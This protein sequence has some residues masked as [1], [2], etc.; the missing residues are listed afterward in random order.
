MTRMLF[1]ILGRRT[2][3]TFGLV[4]FLVGALLATVNLTSRYALKEYVAYQ[5]DRTIIFMILTIFVFVIIFLSIFLRIYLSIYINLSIYRL[6]S[7]LDPC[8]PMVKRSF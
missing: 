4:A 1:G 6:P 2:F 3:L 5:L 8:D 7:S